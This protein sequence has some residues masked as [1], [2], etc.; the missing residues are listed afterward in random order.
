[1]LNA[2]KKLITVLTSLL[3]VVLVSAVGFSAAKPVPLTICM[4]SGN[5][6][7]SSDPGLMDEFRKYMEKATNTTI[8]MIAPPMNTYS[9]K[10]NVLLASG[11]IPDVFQVTKAMVNVHT[12]TQRGYTA[13]LD[14]YIKKNKAFK[15]I[16]PKYFDYMRVNGIVRAI[17]RQQ[18][19]EKFLWM[20]QD[21]LDEYGVKLSSTPTTEEFY[22]EMKKVKGRIPLSFS[23]FLDNLPFF[24]HSFGVYDEFIKDSKGVYYDAF[25]TPEM[26]ECLTYVN[27]L[28][29]EGILD[30]EFPTTDN[31]V[32]RNNLISGKATVNIDYDTRY[33]YYL[34]EIERLDPEAKPNLKPIFKLVGPKGHGGTLN[35]AIQDGIAVSAKCKNPQAAVDLIAWLY[36]TPEG[37]KATRVGLSGKNYTVENGVAKLT[38]AAESGGQ[39]LDMTNVMKLH[40][41]LEKLNFGF[42]FPNEDKSKIYY[43]LVK[44]VS[45][46]TGPKH[47][48]SMGQSRTY[49]RVGQSLIRKRQELALKMIIGA[50]S[51]EDGFKEYEAFYRSING[52]QILKEL[53]AKK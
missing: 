16:D 42:K 4:A 22:R 8:K 6:G 9:E 30:K 45:K 29:S 12:F 17:P 41:P 44:D 2:K 39:A 46:H 47:V 34:S 40:V 5:W 36:F 28:Y 50:S 24:Y 33:F 43:N 1:M 51:I 7:G 3:V 32:L 18:E 35:E 21:L 26:R 53:N 13:P 19:S 10:M 27:R 48:I 14:E 38:P 52:D 25:N 20:R 37:L 31:T 49:D 23:K 15:N 11:D